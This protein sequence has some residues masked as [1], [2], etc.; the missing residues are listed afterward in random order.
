MVIL[1]ERM[2]MITEKTVYVLEDGSTFSEKSMAEKEVLIRTLSKH[3]WRFSKFCYENDN[4]EK[5]LVDARGI[6]EYIANNFDEIKRIID[7]DH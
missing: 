2:T 4:G 5:T 7:N 1:L 6:G 3:A